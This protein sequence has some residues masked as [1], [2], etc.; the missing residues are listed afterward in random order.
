[1]KRDG[2]DDRPAATQAIRRGAALE[3]ASAI[4]DGEPASSI[5]RNDAAAWATGATFAGVIVSVATILAIIG[6]VIA[7][8]FNPVWIGLAQDRAGVPALT[9][10][11]PDQVRATSASIL[12]DVI[13]GPPEFRV[14]VDGNPVLGQT[15][16]L[17]MADV[18]QVMRVFATVMVIAVVALL[19]IVLPNRH[20]AWAWRAVARGSATLAF[21]GIVIS[22]LVVF[23]F[24]AAF[25]AFHLIFFPQGNF[26]FDPRT[27][28]LTALFPEQLFSETAVALALAGLAI[29]LAVT[30]L[31]RR[32]ADRAV[33]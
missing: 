31:A 26:A 13:V 16:R 19:A 18:F 3:T 25:L 11:T 8:V 7:L 23:F 21:A 6:L 9:G 30:L 10:Y 4:V 1:V 2:S 32:A 20:R 15:E 29:A 28:K 5:G 12:A 27:Q 22:L 24:D 14:A 33:G 17:H